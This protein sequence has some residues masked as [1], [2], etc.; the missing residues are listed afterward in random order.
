MSNDIV[1][2]SAIVAEMM[3]TLKHAVTRGAGLAAELAVARLK[4][5]ALEKEL[6][7]CQARQPQE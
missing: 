6:S 4:I 5:S 7:E 3:E 1:K 2:Q